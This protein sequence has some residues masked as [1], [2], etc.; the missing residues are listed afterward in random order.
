M[1]ARLSRVVDRVASDW[2]GATGAATEIEAIGARWLPQMPG[3]GIDV[4]TGAGE[5]GDRA[6][7]ET[8]LIGARLAGTVTR[9][10]HRQTRNLGREGERAAI[11]VPQP[12]IGMNQ[13]ADRRGETAS[14]FCAQRWNGSHG[15]P[16]KG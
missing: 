13:H 3:A 1:K 5:G 4:I 9:I 14:A 2:A 6:G 12:V 10:A 16:S 7:G 8:R 15:G 11:G